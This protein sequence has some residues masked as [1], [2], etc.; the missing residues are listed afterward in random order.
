MSENLNKARVLLRNIH[1]MDENIFEPEIVT[2]HPDFTVL[3]TCNDFDEPQRPFTEIIPNEDLLRLYDYTERIWNGDPVFDD[4]EGTLI[5]IG[6]FDHENIFADLF[7]ALGKTDRN[8]VTRILDYEVYAI[9]RLKKKRQS[10]RLHVIHGGGDEDRQV[11]I[12]DS[13]F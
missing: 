11:N 8:R 7:Y 10:K 3:I 12:P 4:F 6:E 5:N 2:A 1:K 13:P 9:Q